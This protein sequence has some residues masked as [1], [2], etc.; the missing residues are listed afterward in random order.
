LN[1]LENV[2]FSTEE[3]FNPENMTKEKLEDLLDQE[4]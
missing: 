1:E 2:L 3:L 4:K